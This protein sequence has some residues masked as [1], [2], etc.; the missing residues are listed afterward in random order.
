MKRWLHYLTLLRGVVASLIVLA[1]LLVIAYACFCHRAG[2]L[3]SVK[4]E[5][6]V[7]LVGQVKQTFGGP[8]GDAVYVLEDP[9]GAV[10][11]LTDVGLPSEGAVVIVWG[12][13][14]TTEG[15]RAMVVERRRAGTF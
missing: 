6:Y 10:Y 12:K 11:V 13:K 4:E 3:T 15:G 5:G 7:V 2:S 14:T 8:L 1:I 9:S